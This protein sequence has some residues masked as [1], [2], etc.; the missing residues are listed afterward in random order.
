MRIIA[1][2]ALLAG[3]VSAHAIGLGPVGQGQ[4]LVFPYYN[5]GDTLDTL[6][7]VHNETSRPKALKVIVREADQAR[8][9]LSFNLYLAPHDQWSVALSSLNGE[10]ERAAIVTDD[11]TCTV[12][13]IFDQRSTTLPSGLPAVFLSPLLLDDHPEAID[14]LREGMVEI[15]EMGEVVGDAGELVAAQDCRALVNAWVQGFWRDDPATGMAPPGGGLSGKAWLINVLGGDSYSYAAE[16]FTE[17]SSI[18]QHADPSATEPG[19]ANATSDRDDG[20]IEAAVTTQQ[21]ARTALWDSPF[22]AVGALLARAS[23]QTAVT[24]S[25]EL[26]GAT[27]VI[28]ANLGR[29]LDET[30]TSE[31]ALVTW[32]DTGAPGL[33]CDRDPLISPPPPLIDRLVVVDRAVQTLQLAD[34]GILAAR[35]AIDVSERMPDR[36]RLALVAGPGGAADCPL[37]NAILVGGPVDGGGPVRL[38]DAPLVVLSLERVTN[39]TISLP[40]S[41]TVL[42]NYGVLSRATTNLSPADVL[43]Q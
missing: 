16:A 30:T 31:V 15:V 33:D 10:L 21:G 13:S 28:V 4:V 23:H 22:D 11:M 37:E 20:R 9:V 36:G 38:T 26:N 35:N 1:A 25:P 40:G 18:Q 39:G 8:A 3:A 32:D 5:A 43:T 42:S 19:L 29:L 24:R 6:I 17:F 2:I 7:V 14:R 12:P 27:E 34:S 41:G